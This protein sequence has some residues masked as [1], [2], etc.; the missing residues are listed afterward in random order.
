MDTAKIIAVLM[1]SEQNV[2]EIM[3]NGKIIEKGCPL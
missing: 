3:E 1:A 2:K